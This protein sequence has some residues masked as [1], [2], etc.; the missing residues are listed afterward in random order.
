[1]PV[2]SRVQAAV[3]RELYDQ[4]SDATNERHKACDALRR[5]KRQASPGNEH[6]LR[7]AAMREHRALKQV[8]LAKA[9]ISRAQHGE[10]L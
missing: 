7:Q 4:L 2:S 8:K 9:A 10:Q 5:L 3:S 1:M 6:L